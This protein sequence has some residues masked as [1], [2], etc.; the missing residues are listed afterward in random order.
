MNM[1]MTN[2]KLV[3]IYFDELQYMAFQELSKRENCNAADLIRSAMD[4]YLESQKKAES[5]ADWEPLSVGGIKE[6]G[7]WVNKDFQDEML[8]S[9]YDRN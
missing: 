8:G 2:K 5:F 6:N 1:A 4:L 3:S 9:S 7:D